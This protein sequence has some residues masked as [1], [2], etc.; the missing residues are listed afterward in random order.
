MRMCKADIITFGASYAVPYRETW[1]CYEGG[2]VHCGECGTC[3][4]RIEAFRDAQIPDPTIYL[5][6]DD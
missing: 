4:E 1:S 6:D 2:K 5:T 3:I